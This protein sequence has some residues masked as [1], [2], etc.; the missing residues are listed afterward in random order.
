MVL[1]LGCE[2]LDDMG[3]SQAFWGVGGGSSWSQK[4]YIVSLDTDVIG[5]T[6]REIAYE[7]LLW[8]DPILQ[9]VIS[10]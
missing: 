2:S 4:G 3:P 1:E 7:I 5:L 6:G 8:D 9:E 10:E